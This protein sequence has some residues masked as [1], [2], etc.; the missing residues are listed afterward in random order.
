MAENVRV[1][2]EGGNFSD[3]DRHRLEG[4]RMFAIGLDCPTLRHILIYMLVL[5][6]ARGR[7]KDGSMFGVI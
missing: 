6:G 4:K 1:G 7:H 5:V 3:R 2:V